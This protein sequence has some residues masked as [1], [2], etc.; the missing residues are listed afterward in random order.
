MNFGFESNDP[1]PSEVQQWIHEVSPNP[2]SAARAGADFR[3][4][5]LRLMR[6]GDV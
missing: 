6:A 4:G 5:N 1:S 3:Q 2:R